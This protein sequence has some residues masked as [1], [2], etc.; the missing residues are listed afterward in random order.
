MAGL[1]LGEYTALVVA[2]SLSF[3]DAVPL[4]HKRGRFMQEAVPAGEGAMAAILGLDREAVAA[5]CRAAGALGI[6]EPAN[7][8]C[9]GQVVVSGQAAAVAEAVRLARVRGAKARL[10]P[11]SAPFHSSLVAPARERLAAE[12]AQV[13]V[14][15]ARVPVVANAHA[16]YVQRADEIVS[17]LVE[18]VTRPVL[19]EESVRRLLADG[20][21]VFAEVGPGNALAGFV[22][23]IDRRVT[24]YNVQDVPSLEVVL[25]RLGGLC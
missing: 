11:V 25:D 24:V 10:L 6:V 9:P 16:G 5:V 13:T 1:S 15:D 4:V 7:F 12:L 22:R 8:N 23:R 14:R 17:A 19:W 20:V 2:G 3:D 21:E 18:Q